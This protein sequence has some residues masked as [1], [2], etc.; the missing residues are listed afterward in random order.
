MVIVSASSDAVG[1]ADWALLCLSPPP[2]PHPLS[3]CTLHSSH[4]L[5]YFH[6]NQL[7]SHCFNLMQEPGL[8][9]SSPAPS[10]AVSMLGP[11][12]KASGAGG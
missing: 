10:S 12:M 8:R 1:L 7:D 3:S 11:V 4:S 9:P 2:S 5:S 6:Q